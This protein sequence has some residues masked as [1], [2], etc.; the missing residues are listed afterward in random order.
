VLLLV[1][2]LIPIAISISEIEKDKLDKSW[3]SLPQHLTFM[4]FFF[5][6]AAVSLMYLVRRIYWL[7][8]EKDEEL[9]YRSLKVG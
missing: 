5:I 7:L 4:I 9:R 3:I 1:L 8:L 2:C 6:L